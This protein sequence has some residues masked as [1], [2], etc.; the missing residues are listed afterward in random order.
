MDRKNREGVDMNY[1]QG[2]LRKTTNIQGMGK[3]IIDTNTQN[4]RTEPMCKLQTNLFRPNQLQNIH[5]NI[6]R[7]TKNLYN[8]NQ[9]RNKEFLDQKI[10][11]AIIY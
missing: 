8:Q 6:V 7:E 11:Q 4:R 9:E 5:K 2:N 1:M 3:P 10:R